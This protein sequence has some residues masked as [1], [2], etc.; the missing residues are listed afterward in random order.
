MDFSRVTTPQKVDA[1][2]SFAD[3]KDFISIGQKLDDPLKAFALM[4]GM[5]DLVKGIVSKSGG[6]V[7]KFIGDAWLMIYPDDSV[8]RG[9]LGIIEMKAAVEKY[10]QQNGFSN[11]LRTTAHFGE[12]A[13]GPF[14]GQALD[15]FGANVNTAATLEKSDRRGQL[16]ISPQAFRKLAPSTRK[17]FHKHTPPVVYIAEDQ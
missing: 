7:V 16:I 5:A 8:D 17:L 3:I 6:Y 9:I 11:K 12:V 14:A 1:L 13:V 10:L 4:N 2:V 15:V